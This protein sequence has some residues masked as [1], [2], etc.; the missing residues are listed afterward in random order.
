MVLTAG[1]R[2]HAPERVAGMKADGFGEVDKRESNFKV[3]GPF[4]N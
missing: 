1:E 2:A 4:C 3:F